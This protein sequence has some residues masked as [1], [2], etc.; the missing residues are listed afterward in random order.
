MPRQSPLPLTNGK[1]VS[2]FTFNVTYPSREG[3]I[4]MIV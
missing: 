1:R 2:R 4:G 3:R